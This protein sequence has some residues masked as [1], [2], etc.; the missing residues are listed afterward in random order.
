MLAQFI[1]IDN[2]TKSN[3]VVATKPPPTS[4]WYFPESLEIL[5][6]QFEA[7]ALTLGG[8]AAQAGRGS[9]GVEHSN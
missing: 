1:K 6:A 8:L 7:A 9:W 2:Y 4:P 5:M 3:K